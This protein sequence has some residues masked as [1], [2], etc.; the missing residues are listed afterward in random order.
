MATHFSILAQRISRTEETGGLQSMSSNSMTQQ[1]KGEGGLNK[2]L[3]KIE[4]TW[5]K[6][7]IEKESQHE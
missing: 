6:Q 1:L 7:G 4:D 3:V 5:A 2:N